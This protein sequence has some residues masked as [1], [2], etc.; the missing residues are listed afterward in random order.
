[1]DDHECPA[2][3][4]DPLIVIGGDRD[5][6]DPREPNYCTRCDHHHWLP[7]KEYTFFTLNPL[8]E[9]AARGDAKPLRQELIRLK[10]NPRKSALYSSLMEHHMDRN[11]PQPV[12]LNSLMVP[13]IA[14]K[15]LLY[16]FVEQNLVGR[17]QLVELTRE[18]NLD[19]EYISGRLGD[20]R[21]SVDMD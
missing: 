11:D 9:A 14:E 1:M 10:D 8:G 21:R 13:C 15:A 17:D 6:K 19:V 7:G 18:L 2:L 16:L 4:F 5:K 12:C 3:Y 20:N